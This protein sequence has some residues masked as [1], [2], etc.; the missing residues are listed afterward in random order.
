MEISI[1]DYINQSLRCTFCSDSNISTEEV[2]CENNVLMGRIMCKNCRNFV[3]IK[4]G[5]LDYSNQYNED[6]DR[7]D[8]ANQ[9]IFYNTW[10]LAPKNY[11]SVPYDTEYEVYKQNYKIFDRKIVLDAGCG[12]GR[13]FEFISQFDI[14]LGILID[15]GQSIELAQ[16][17][18]SN[19]YNFPILFIRANIRQMP[20]KNNSVD[21][22][23]SNGVL[24]HVNDQGE[25]LEEFSKISKNII[26]VGIVTSD[27]FLGRIWIRGNV[28]R[29]VLKKI[30]S[31]NT[32][33]FLAY[34]SSKVVFFFISIIH[35]FIRNKSFSALFEIVISDKFKSQKLHYLMLDYLTAPFY[36]KHKDSYYFEIMKRSGFKLKEKS[37]SSQEVF[38]IFNKE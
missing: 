24:H 5:I 25:V 8:Y 27:K 38:F 16:E 35:V 3:E 29:K 18:F 34:L 36:I 37:Y 22:I 6:I 30:K 12:S 14:K 11:N 1:I 10:K 21:S 17:R 20:L 15:I 26:L 23:I 32:L 4:N 13:A 9:A 2:F 7:I 28:I 31:T 19:F 33:I